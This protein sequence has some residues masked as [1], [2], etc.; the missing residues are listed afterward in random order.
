MEPTAAAA[1]DLT[2]TADERLA[3]LSTLDLQAQS[4]EWLSRQ[5]ISTL[6]AWRAD[7]TVLD[8]E[9]EGRADF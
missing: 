2:G 3:Q 4:A 8:I 6:E 5:L 9:E 1:S 7:E